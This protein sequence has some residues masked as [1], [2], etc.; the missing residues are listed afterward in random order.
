MRA[1]LMLRVYGI[2]DEGACGDA[3]R[4]LFPF[5]LLD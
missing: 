1:T 3:G 2:D 4:N 5:D